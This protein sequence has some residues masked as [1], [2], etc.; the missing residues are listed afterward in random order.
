MEKIKYKVEKDKNFYGKRFKS[1]TVEKIITYDNGEVE[2]RY[3]TIF[4]SIDGRINTINFNKL[5][6]PKPITQEE[7]KKLSPEYRKAWCNG[8]LTKALAKE[9]N[10]LRM[11]AGAAE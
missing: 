3:R 9:L 10:D 8:T 7:W 2:H 1:Y 4:P 6:F 5:G 11:K